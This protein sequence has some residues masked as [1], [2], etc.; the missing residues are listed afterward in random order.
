MLFSLRPTALFLL[1]VF[2]IAGCS[3]PTTS[4]DETVKGD[5]TPVISVPVPTSVDWTGYY[6][7]TFPDGKDRHT[8][9]A[10]WI[11][12]D[13]TF[14][15]HQ[16]RAGHDSIPEGLIGQWNVA[17][18][19]G[20]PPQGL[21]RIP[22]QGDPPDHYLPTERGLTWVDVIGGYDVAEDWKLERLA[23]EIGDAIP[24]MRLMGTFT[25]VAD[26]QSFQPCGSKFNWPCVGGMDMGEEEGEPLVKFTNVDLQREYRNW[27]KADGVP[28]VVEVICTL[29]MGPAMEGDGAD[30]YVYIEQVERTLEHCP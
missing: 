1:L 30:E 8:D 29:G 25:Y 19:D 2:L 10:L 27:V 9:V 13:S 16:F 24:R 20:G 22:L 4:G 5:T 7:G 21:L 26:A 12:S 28:W 11:R 18:V 17:H 15:L 23:D 6:A 14:V 3:S